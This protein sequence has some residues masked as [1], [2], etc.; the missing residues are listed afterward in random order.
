MN[1]LCWSTQWMEAILEPNFKLCCSTREGIEMLQMIR[2]DWPIHPKTRILLGWVWW[3][4]SVISATWEV[5]RG[6]LWFETRLGKKVSKTL[7]QK[8]YW[9]WCHH[10]GFQCSPDLFSCWSNSYLLG[11]GWQQSNLASNLKYSAFHFC[12]FP[13][14]ANFPTPT[15]RKLMHLY[16]LPQ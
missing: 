9:V 4:M 2:W 1:T 7:S 6:G 13:F 10:V 14:F 12:F 3:L 11:P 16:S 15:L 8:S 5:E